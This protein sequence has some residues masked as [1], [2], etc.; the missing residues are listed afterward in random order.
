[1]DSILING[2]GSYAGI[3]KGKKIRTCF[4]NARSLFFDIPN[5]VLL[6]KHFRAVNIF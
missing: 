2:N 5:Q 6:K 3:V 1:M 4:I